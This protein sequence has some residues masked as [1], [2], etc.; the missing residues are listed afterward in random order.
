MCV[1]VSFYAVLCSF[2]L[3]IIDLQG[4]GSKVAVGLPETGL[5]IIPV[6]VL[7]CFCTVFMVVLC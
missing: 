2:M 3:N 1:I 5:A 7:C 4:D 6:G